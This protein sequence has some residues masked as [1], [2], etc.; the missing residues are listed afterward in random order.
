MILATAVFSFGAVFVSVSF[1]PPALPVYTQP[2]CPGPG[3]IWVPGYW[4]WSPD[5][6]DYYWVPGTWVLAPQ[7]G[8][9]WTPGYWGFSSGLYYWHPGYWG[10]TVGF[11]GG[12]N[13]G[14]GYPGY[15][16]YGG[17][18]HGR[19]FYYNRT[20]NNVNITN[21]RYVYNQPV[22]NNFNGTRVAYNGGPGGVQAQPTQAQLAAER[23][24]HMAATPVQIQHE[25]A[26]RRD[27]AQFVARNH[28]T[29][30]GGR[31][32]ETWSLERSRSSARESAGRKPT[33]A[34]S[35]REQR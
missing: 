16:Y 5:Y 4:A 23:Q 1:G 6:G 24:R 9:L 3:Y 22:T 27:P 20:V 14:W 26:A 12:I 10:L 8:F 30:R 31:D 11:Y 33:G 28:G 35:K 13:Y 19:D 32:A 34:G 7:P 2:F 17:Y 15:G 25:Q 29:S 18:W 21:V